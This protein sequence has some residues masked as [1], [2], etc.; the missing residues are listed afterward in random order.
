MP[1]FQRK[2]K[3][4]SRASKLA[5]IQA[6][7]IRDL[8]IN[9]ANIPASQIEIIKITTSGDKIKDISLAEIGG[10]GLFIK[11]LEENLIEKK[12]DIAVHSAKDVTP[13][14]HSETI[15]SAFTKRLDANDYFISK[16]YKTI[17]NLPLGASI[18]TSSTR[19]KA[20]LLSMR[21]DLNINV[22]RGNVDSRLRKIFEEK[23]DA[24]VIAL[25][26]LQRM[27]VE[28]ENERIIPTNTMIPAVGQGSLALQIRRDDNV[29]LELSKFINDYESY[30]CIKAERA[31][32]RELNAS[33]KSPIGVYAILKDN[34][35]ILKTAI[36][37][38]DGSMKYCT[39]NKITI[40]RSNIDADS[41]IT[42]ARSAALET[43]K[44]ASSILERIC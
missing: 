13:L 41:L 24:S 27:G 33:C 35:F 19:R 44:N 31:F 40:D 36:Y 5:L 11:E 9:K 12:I 32:L 10:K 30:V 17:N 43:I 20:I 28:I 39:N 34:S 6:N 15:L 1:E 4:G 22:L 37:D 18:G 29:C 7:E 16:K 38:I 42:I 2:I 14:I 26:A 3:I 8:L 21:S 25:C 23:F